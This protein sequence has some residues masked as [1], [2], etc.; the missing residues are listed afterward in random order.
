MDSGPG[1]G[2]PWAVE[3]AG[4]GGERPG[5]REDEMRVFGGAV[6]HDGDG[7]ARRQK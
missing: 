2:P 1:D 3:S 5:E 6:R 7:P 4:G